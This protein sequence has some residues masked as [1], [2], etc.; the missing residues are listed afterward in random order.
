HRDLK[1]GNVLV[2]TVD[3]KPVPKIIDFGIAK[4]AGERLT[5]RTLHTETHQIL[6]TPQY[7]SPEQ[8]AMSADVDTRS[9]VYSLGVILYELLTGR[10]PFDAEKL[11]SAGYA[12]LERIITSEEP[13]TPSAR[14]AE[15]GADA[16]E[17]AGQ[18]GTDPRSHLRQV[19]GEVEWVVL[20]AMRK[21]RHL[22]YPTANAMAEDLER[23]LTGMPVM[24]NP[25][26]RVYRLR[27]MAHRYRWQVS[28]AAFILLLIIG[29]AVTASLLAYSADR[30]R[31]QAETESRRSNQITR[32]MM[33]VI[34]GV[35]PAVARGKDT[36]LMRDILD[37][38]DERIDASEALVK[39][40]AA[41]VE[42][43]NAI[44]YAYL[45]IGAAD[46]ARQQFQRQAELAQRA[47]GP[48]HE[49]T[50]AADADLG[51]AL[52][53]SGRLDEAI[54]MLT[55][56]ARR[57]RGTL[58]PEHKVTLNLVSNLANAHLVRDE[59]ELAEPLVRALYESRRASLGIDDP[60]TQLAL[61]NLAN[62]LMEQSRFEEAES[63]FDTLLDAQRRKDPGHPYTLATMNNLGRVYHQTGRLEKARAMYSESLEAKK[64]ILPAGHPSLLVSYGNLGNFLL[65]AE[66]YEGAV[67]TYGEALDS[68][69]AEA[70]QPG[71]PTL[72]RLQMSRALMKLDRNAEAAA[73]IERTL[74]EMTP[75]FGAEHEHTIGTVSR[76]GLA[77]T[78]A[79]E[80]GR[81]VLRTEEALKR[82][83]VAFPAGDSR[84]VYLLN[85][86]AEAMTALG[87][88]DE[89]R[90]AL[91][92][93][94][95]LCTSPAPEREAECSRAAALLA[96]LE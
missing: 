77:L 5:D 59:Y 2:T 79:G 24:A 3:G 85:N 94:R 13:A 92:E 22:R 8:V 65:D 34:G 41:E 7:M 86:H 49:T 52:I 1:P 58:G 16:H 55:D 31:K 95:G 43:R 29:F 60:E 76:L 20:R 11:K 12:G 54:P 61:N 46:N 71:T 21:D 88:I 38:A 81:G 28:V 48:D 90:A 17:V 82:G 62:V 6:G 15:L 83:R 87:R 51:G 70:D 74:P 57:A 56:A 91:E 10:P 26:G 36:A 93:A 35:D 27:K 9:D 45:S 89:A 63:C 66:D 68:I 75:L 39:D 44:G 53:Q 69:P 67:A 32:F 73:L 30:A 42:V 37:R 78:N 40:P 64:R 47:F 84:L 80:A 18:R 4:A 96:E 19:R 50:F 72:I 23:L 14:V 33:D 25:L